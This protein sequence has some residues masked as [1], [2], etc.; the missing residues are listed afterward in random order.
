MENCL[1]NYYYACSNA[2]IKC[3]VCAAGRSRSST[4]I[5]FNPVEGKEYLRPHPYQAILEEKIKEDKRKVVSSKKEKKSNREFKIKSKLIKTSFKKEKEVVDKF[6]K[7]VNQADTAALKQTIASGSVHG[8][9][10][11]KSVYGILQMDHKYRTKVNNFTLSRGEYIEGKSQ[12][13]NSWVITAGK[14]REEE[15]TVV[16]LTEE[17]FSNLLALA[18]ESHGFRKPEEKI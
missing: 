18:L 11:I 14:T 8:D 4:K 3:G 6:N 17:A 1:D 10:D 9:G 12:G 2:S 5:F 15:S 16:I 7:Y 13:T